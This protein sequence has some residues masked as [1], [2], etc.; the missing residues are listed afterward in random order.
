MQKRCGELQTL[1]LR[2][3]GSKG[4]CDD[5]YAACMYQRQQQ[6]PDESHRDPTMVAKAAKAGKW[7]PF[8]GQGW[9]VWVGTAGIVAMLV[10]LV[11]Y[12]VMSRRKTAG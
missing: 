2:R 7:N 4:T 8:E 12:A 3:G 10:L 6:Q 5:A 9:A 11:V 1:C